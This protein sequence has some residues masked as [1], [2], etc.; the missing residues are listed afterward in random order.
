MEPTRPVG[1]HG[2]TLRMVGDDQAERIDVLHLTHL[3]GDD[4]MVFAVH[5]REALEPGKIRALHPP[6]DRAAERLRH[7]HETPAIERVDERA[8]RLRR[9]IGLVLACGDERDRANDRDW[10][11]DRGRDRTPLVKPAD[12]HV[13]DVTDRDRVEHQR[14]PHAHGP[15]EEGVVLEPR[16]APIGIIASLL[17]A[18]APIPPEPKATPMRRQTGARGCRSYGV[19]RVDRALAASVHCRGVPAD[20]PRRGVPPVRPAAAP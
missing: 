20:A 8:R 14:R 12:D 17:L 3:V 19:P 1:H 2:S 13:A 18:V 16:V 10:N 9:R 5:R 11:D 6:G 15:H 7:G 4:D